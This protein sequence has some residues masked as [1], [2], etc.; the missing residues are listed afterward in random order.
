MQSTGFD[1]FTSRLWL[2]VCWYG[3]VLSTVEV[4]N[5]VESHGNELN[6]F[7]ISYLCVFQWINPE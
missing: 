4:G 2:L 5:F 7:N 6:K 3:I 1:L